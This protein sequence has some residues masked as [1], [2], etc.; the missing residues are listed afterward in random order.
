MLPF[1]EAG[2]QLLTG[3]HMATGSLSSTILPVKG[4]DIS[5]DS[6]PP[7]ICLTTCNGDG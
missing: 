5:V 7:F 6:K 3:I 4:P 2:M 1:K